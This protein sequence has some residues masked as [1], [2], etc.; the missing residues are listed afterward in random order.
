[1]THTKV[2]AQKSKDH[3]MNK[4][5]PNQRE[6]LCFWKRK[7]YL[8]SGPISTKVRIRAAKAIISENS[9]LD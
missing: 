4:A 3:R 2:S 6:A 1:M 8:K 5:L 7:G 9:N